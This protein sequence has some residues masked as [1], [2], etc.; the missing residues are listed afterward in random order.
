MIH[1]CMIMKHLM[2]EESYTDRKNQI[3]DQKNISSTIRTIPY[4]NRMIVWNDCL[5]RS[6]TKVGRMR[7]RDA[8]RQGGKSINHIDK[9]AKCH[10]FLP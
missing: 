1:K 5:I 3:K 7:T 4:P 9:N 8:H 10:I 2:Y 6:E